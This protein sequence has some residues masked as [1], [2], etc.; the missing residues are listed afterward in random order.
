MIEK[1]M[2]KRKEP[3]KSVSVN[4]ELFSLKHAFRKAEDW[5]YVTMSP[6]REVKPLKSDGC[7]RDLF[8]TRE[9][10]G[11][12]L[13]AA[14][15]YDSTSRSGWNLRNEPFSD[16]WALSVI[17]TECGLRV[18][19]ILSLEHSDVNLGSKMLRIR[20]KPVIAFVVK[21]HAERPIPLTE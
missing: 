15:I 7:V 2:E 4:R 20:N 10:Y 1:Y 9:Q 6:A 8:L 5:K 16:T 17:G 19:E 11:T 12:L 14:E 13:A 18:G 21:N 3:V